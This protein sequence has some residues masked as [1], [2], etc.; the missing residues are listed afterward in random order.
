M[1]KAAVFDL[2]HTLFDRY[3][4]FR[5]MIMTASEDELP[6]DPAVPREKAL[7]VLIALDRL[8]ICS[9]EWKGIAVH[10]QELGVARKDMQIDGFFNQ[11]IVSLFERVAVPFPF[12]H[13]MLKELRDMGI[14]TGLITNGRHSLQARK[15]ELLG[16]QD[17]LDISVI[18]GD[19]G[20]HKPDV[21]VFEY[22]F[23]K[24]PSVR[25]EEMLY[26]GDN[27]LN[28][29]EGSRRA[30][31]IPVWVRTT[32]VWPFPEL[33]KPPLQVDTVE[34]IPSLIRRLNQQTRRT[35][36]ETH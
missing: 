36:Y 20:F 21:G 25:P 13:R 3:A 26:I 8:Y 18:S 16:I 6:F 19:T 9:E 10:L 30:G 22:F 15:L 28:D 2:D 11:Y 12:T 4:T 27:P 17:L 24:L 31:M 35:L 32:G 5:E 7:E 14:F 29:V 23:K 33:E 1:I 34:E